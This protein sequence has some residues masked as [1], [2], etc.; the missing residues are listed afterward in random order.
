MPF[1]D[2]GRPKAELNIQISETTLHPGAEFRARVEL[3]PREDFHVRLG[4]VEL[5]CLETCVSS[6]RSASTSSG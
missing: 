5:V 2:F 1:S 4:M 6:R 3:V